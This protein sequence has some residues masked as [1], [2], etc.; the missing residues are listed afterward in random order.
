MEST[1]L[2]KHPSPTKKHAPLLIRDF[3][4]STAFQ[5]LEAYL[6]LSSIQK[7]EE[8]AYLQLLALSQSPLTLYL[9]L[10]ATKQRLILF[11]ATIH[12]ILAMNALLDF[13]AD[14]KPNPP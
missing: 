7:E 14:L 3:I 10:R 4:L 2:S 11:E 1:D 5:V 6:L 12:V 9:L 8:E 13:L